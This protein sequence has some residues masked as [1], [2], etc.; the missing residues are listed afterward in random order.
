MTQLNYNELH[1]KQPIW[2]WLYD[3][4]AINYPEMW[5]DN[6]HKKLTYPQ[7]HTYSFTSE[8]EALLHPSRMGWEKDHP[9][10]LQKT[11]LNGALPND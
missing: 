11:Y 5:E 7:A 10:V 6:E 9:Y 4:G 3:F 1:M 8:V 2:V